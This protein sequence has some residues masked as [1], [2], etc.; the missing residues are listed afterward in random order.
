MIKAV[1]KLRYSR[2]DGYGYRLVLEIDKGISMFYRSL[3]PKWFR[4]NPLRALPHI[5][6]IRK[7]TPKN[8]KAWGKYEGEVVEFEYDTYLHTDGKT[9]WWLNCYSKRLEE[10]AEELG[11]TPFVNYFP[12]AKGYRK[13]WHTTVANMKETK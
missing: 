12:P 1:G 10:I 6:I 4:T 7:E 8:L 11:M 13:I 2:P 9:Y 3:I 5:T